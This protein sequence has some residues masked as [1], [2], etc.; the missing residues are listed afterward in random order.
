LELAAGIT[1]A[2][3]HDVA[4]PGTNNQFL[5]ASEVGSSFARPL[6]GLEPLQITQPTSMLL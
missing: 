6:Q 4:H 1:A 3:I 2:I 5:E